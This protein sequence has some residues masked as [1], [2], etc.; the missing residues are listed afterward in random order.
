MRGWESPLGARGINPS[1]VQHELSDNIIPKL[2]QSLGTPAAAARASGSGQ[3][4]GVQRT[5]TTTPLVEPIDPEAHARSTLSLCSPDSPSLSQRFPS[6]WS[7]ARD[8]A[9]VYVGVLSRSMP[10]GVI[11]PSPVHYPVGVCK[12]LRS[13]V[14]H[15][16]ELLS[17][18]NS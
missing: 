8:G 18:G 16:Y 3:G 5:T 15:A 4:N 12:C 6:V 13:I 11:M 17:T 10:M 9:S 7:P 2:G 14:G 1:V